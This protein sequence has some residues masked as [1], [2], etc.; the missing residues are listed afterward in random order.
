MRL[1]TVVKDSDTALGLKRGEHR[2]RPIV[3]SRAKPAFGFVLHIRFLMNI[4][5]HL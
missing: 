1:G 4:R 5:E 3:H 2:M